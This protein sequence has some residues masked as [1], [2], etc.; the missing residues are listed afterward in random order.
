MHWCWKLK[1][2]MGLEAFLRC[3]LGLLLLSVRFHEVRGRVMSANVVRRCLVA[4]YR[5]AIF[6]AGLE[7]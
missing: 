3:D 6:Y 4:V 5:E 1:L 7:D 2:L